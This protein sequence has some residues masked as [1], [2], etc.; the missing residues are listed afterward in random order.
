MASMRHMTDVRHCVPPTTS[1]WNVPTSA[2]LRSIIYDPIVEGRLVAQLAAKAAAA[3]VEV[4]GAHVPTA[5][6]SA[7]VA[8]AKALAADVGSVANAPA[9]AAKAAA[10]AAAEAKGVSNG[11]SASDSEASAQTG[12]RSAASSDLSFRSSSFEHTR[13]TG[14]VAG[15]ASKHQGPLQHRQ[16]RPRQRHSQLRIALG[17]CAC[18][19][20]SGAAHE[21]ILAY[22]V[23]A[24]HT[25]YWFV[26]FLVQVRAPNSSLVSVIF[27]LC[28]VEMLAAGSCF[29]WS[30]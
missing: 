3:G 2:M 5:P 14:H 17:V 27:A 30:K 15:S 13:G 21:M 29:S 16:Q 10:P 6:P 23:P 12:M 20:V 24:A 9:T 19:A 25:Y 4:P 18:F 11:A 7:A 8:K 22:A 1:R 26:F 28:D